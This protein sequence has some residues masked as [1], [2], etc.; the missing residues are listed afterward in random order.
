MSGNPDRLYRANA[1]AHYRRGTDYGEA[2]RLSFAWGHYVHHAVVTALLVAVA[3]LVCVP[4]RDDVRGPGFVRL[5]G[6]RPVASLLDG[7]VAHVVAAPGQRVAAGDPVLE[8]HQPELVAQVDRLTKEFDGLWLRL[9]RD[10]L[11]QDAR[12]AM[13]LTQPALRRAKSLLAEATV[14]A[15]IDGVVTDVRVTEGRHVAKGDTLFVVV[16]AGARAEIV[17]VIPA[18]VRPQ[19][20]LDSSTRFWVDGADS[21]TPVELTELRADAIGPSEVSRLLG[22]TTQGSLAVEGMS[23]VVTGAL[24]EAEFQSDGQARRFYQGMSGQ[25]DVAL[26]KKPILF[27]LVPGLRRWVYR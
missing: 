11:D 8:L 23:V 21:N 6:A 17:A 2:L 5:V 26:D 14:R 10:P 18:S 7:P 3:A 12:Q 24:R 13:T 19:V 25:I 9:L 15:P 22:P 16:P 1:W 27:L 20:S 4:I